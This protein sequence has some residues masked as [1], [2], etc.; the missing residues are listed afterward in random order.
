MPRVEIDHVASS[1]LRSI[2]IPLM[3]L[4]SCSRWCQQRTP[5]KPAGRIQLILSKQLNLAKDDSS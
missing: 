5:F 2:Q 3:A 4:V 1:L